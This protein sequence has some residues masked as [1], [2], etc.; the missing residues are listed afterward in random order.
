MALSNSSSSRI[1]GRPALFKLA[2]IGLLACSAPAFPQA[3]PETDT[4]ALLE[5]GRQA[6][7]DYSLSL[8]DFVCTEVVYR[9]TDPYGGRQ[10]LPVRASSDVWNLTDT[11]TVQ[12]G[13]FEHKE[14]HK[15]TL[16]DGKPTNRTYDSLGG[17]LGAGEFGGMLHSIFNPSSQA[18][19]R[20]VSW[21]NVRRGAA[22]G[23]TP[24][25][26]SSRIRVTALCPVVR[27]APNGP[28]RLSR[29]IGYR[30]G[31][32]R[33]ARFHLRSGQHP[34]ELAMGLRNHHRELRLYGRRR[35]ELSDCR[36]APKQ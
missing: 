30:P 34:K 24:T 19:F 12:L 1:H 3:P 18:S 14:E 13:Y 21:K 23:S 9:Y 8:P 25:R 33:R 31:N 27:R 17:V 4:A 15:L 6:A 32:G 26:Y 5:K 28:G 35:P 11:L 10:L 36:R 22:P 29:R 16:I 20:W 7:L 2:A